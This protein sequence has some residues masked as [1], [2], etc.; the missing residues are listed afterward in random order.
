[1]RHQ[2]FLL[3]RPEER[4]R[5]INTAFSQFVIEAVGYDFEI[6]RFREREL[7]YLHD[8][9]AVGVVIDPDLVRKERLP[10]DVETREGEEY[11]KVLEIPED[12]K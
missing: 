3:L 1:M 10:L 6:H 11:G 2:V 7:V 8:P 12:L 5:P 9:L 4:L